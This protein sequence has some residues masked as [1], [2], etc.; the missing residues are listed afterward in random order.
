MTKETGAVATLL[1][2]AAPPGG[3][4]VLVGSVGGTDE[5]DSELLGVACP[6]VLAMPE[7]EVEVEVPW[8]VEGLGWLLLLEIA[9]VGGLLDA[10]SGE[11]PV[12]VSL[13]EVPLLIDVVL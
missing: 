2:S 3:L 4:E 9:P 7:I 13:L 10:T 5:T 8:D 12:E 1:R 6:L 11:D